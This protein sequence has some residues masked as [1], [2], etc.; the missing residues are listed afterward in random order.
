MNMEYTVRIEFSRKSLYEAEFQQMALALFSQ[1]EFL[2]NPLVKSPHPFASVY[3]YR[4]P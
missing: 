4:L 1:L 3:P 2:L